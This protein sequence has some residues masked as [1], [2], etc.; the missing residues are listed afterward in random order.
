MRRRPLS[1]PRKKL[2]SR[3]FTSF[4]DAFYANSLDCMDFSLV[5][6]SSHL[7][8]G[9]GSAFAAGAIVGFYK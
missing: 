4:W 9:I 6:C 3:W 7:A 2:V 1:S 8:P 5:L